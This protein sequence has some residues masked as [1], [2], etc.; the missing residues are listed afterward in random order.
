MSAGSAVEGFHKRDVLCV[1]RSHP[2]IQRSD[3]KARERR[4]GRCE[5]GERR[6]RTGCIRGKGT[7]ERLTKVPTGN[8]FEANNIWTLVCVVK[9]SPEA[10][11]WF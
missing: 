3:F 6:A 4:G 8:S 10:A 7:P 9:R 5:A 11:R 2:E 1:F